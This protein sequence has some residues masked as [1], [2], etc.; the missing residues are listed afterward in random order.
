MP[1]KVTKIDKNTNIILIK[2]WYNYCLKVKFWK[3][4]KFIFNPN[5]QNMHTFD[6]SIPF[7][8]TYSMIKNKKKEHIY[9]CKDISSGKLINKG[10]NYGRYNLNFYQKYLNI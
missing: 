4:V 9:I 2:V 3:E 7:L 1:I 5:F 8:R 6:I 10:K